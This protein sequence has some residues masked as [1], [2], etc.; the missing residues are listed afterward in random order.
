MNDIFNGVTSLQELNTIGGKQMPKTKKEFPEN[1][2]D[3]GIGTKE[4]VR[5]EPAEVEIIA[6]TV[7]P[8]GDKGAKKVVCEVK[9]PSAEEHI[10]ISSA[11]AERKGKLEATGLWFNPDDE[12]LIRKGSMLAEFLTFMKA[13]KVSELAGKKCMTVEDTSGY[14]VF[15]AY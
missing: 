2:E 15:K 1:P 10:R 3:T 14:L 11:K 8:V 13:G 5:L 4:A 12:G 6:A 9:H 7:E